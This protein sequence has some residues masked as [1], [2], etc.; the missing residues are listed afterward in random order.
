MHAVKTGGKPFLGILLAVAVAALPHGVAFAQSGPSTQGDLLSPAERAAIQ[1]TTI[2]SPPVPPVGA[3][4]P[5]ALQKSDT[6][7]MLAVPTST[8]TYGCTATSAGM[9]FAYYDRN[10]YPNMYTGPA[11]GGVCP[12]TDVGQ[13][14]ST[15][16]ATACSII[17]TQNGFDGRTVYGHADDYY[18]DYNAAGPDPWEGVRAEHAWGG[19]TA[20]YMGTNQWKWDYDS[21]GAKDTS[22]DGATTYFSYSSSGKLYDYIPP[23]SQGT[24]QTE[25]CHGMRLFAESRGYTVTENYTQNIDTRYAGGFSF[26][27]YKAEIDAARPVMIHLAGH[28]IV[29]VGYDDTT[30]T[31]YLNDTWDNSVHSMTW[32][33]SYAGM[34]Q[35]AVTI[36]RLAPDTT[37][38][39]GTIVI[40]N[41]LSVTNNPAVT[42]AL[43][44]S[45]G[46]GSGVVRMR[47]SGDGANWSAWEPLAAT[48]AF[49]LPGPDG[50]NTIRVQF[51]D[52]AGN[53][54]AV[55]SD[56]IRLDTVPPTG[57]IVINGG[58]STTSTTSVS[59]GLTWSDGTGS[60]VVRMRFSDNGANWTPWETLKATRAYAMPGGLGY[61]TIRAQYRDAGGNISAAVNDYIKLVAP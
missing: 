28:T 25:A 12:M 15:P 51:R 61:H 19:C 9:I 30:S 34:A 37:A 45:D 27:D 39:T 41:N 1:P 11:N 26:A 52:L 59:L 32:G 44:W 54:S 23:A 20:D 31:V 24:P 46:T 55:F 29:G 43:T 33:G 2:G 53:N 18:Y 7:K 22:T 8:W 42:L 16:I 60:G 17:A 5:L 58:A 14:I 4:R 47:F 13:G 36:I 6:A 3:A 49:T 21:N 38:P 57:S 10:G 40:N 35:Q 50:Y 56:Y 48:R